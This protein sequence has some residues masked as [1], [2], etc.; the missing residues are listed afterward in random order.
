MFYEDSFSDGWGPDPGPRRETPK[1][2][3]PAQATVIEAAGLVGRVAGR[4]QVE[5]VQLLKQLLVHTAAALQALE[6]H[7]ETCEIFYRVG[8]EMAVACRAPDW[9]AL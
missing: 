3:P 1:E 8:D 6:G 9:R 2:T 4:P 5:Q 7:V